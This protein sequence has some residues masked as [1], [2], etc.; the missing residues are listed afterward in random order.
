MRTALAAL[1]LIVAEGAA[2][3]ADCRIAKVLFGNV[4][5]DPAGPDGEAYVRQSISV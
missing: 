3:A 5:I 1:A 2:Q 4:S